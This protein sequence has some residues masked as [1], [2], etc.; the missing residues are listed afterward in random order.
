GEN[1]VEG[2]HTVDCGAGAYCG[3]VKTQ[4]YIQSGCFAP[5]ACLFQVGC[6]T[7]PK[8]GHFCCCNT[9]YC[10]ATDRSRYP[11]MKEPTAAPPKPA[12]TAAAPSPAVPSHAVPSPSNSR[13]SPS[14]NNPAA[15]PTLLGALAA[16]AGAIAAQI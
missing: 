4:G 10:D 12:A 13:P 3:A 7:T 8:G 11:E 16:V 5:K 1:L 9:D 6:V 2:F 14:S 15:A